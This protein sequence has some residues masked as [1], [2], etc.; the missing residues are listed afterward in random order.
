MSCQFCFVYQRIL[1]YV[2]EKTNR[3]RKLEQS[4]AEWE[5]LKLQN[6]E[7]QMKR[8][9]IINNSEKEILSLETSL[10]RWRKL[11]MSETE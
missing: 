6:K 10:K 5:K 11:F 4:E 3:K 8:R 2:A 1:R 7:L 9:L